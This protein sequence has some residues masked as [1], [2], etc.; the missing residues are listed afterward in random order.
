AV[1][2]KLE[3]MLAAEYTIRG[4]R[5]RLEQLEFAA[6]QFGRMIRFGVEKLVLRPVEAPVAENDFCNLAMIGLLALRLGHAAAQKGLNAGRE[7]AHLERLSQVIVRAHL[8]TD[9][10]IGR[11]ALAADDDDVGLG[12]VSYRTDQVQAVLIGKDK[13]QQNNIWLRRVDFFQHL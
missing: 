4:Q 8:Q 7:L 2:R 10:T 13:I 6:G 11:F 3:K 12:L 5:Q 1:A 9:D